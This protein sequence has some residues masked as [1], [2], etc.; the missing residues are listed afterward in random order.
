MIEIK[1]VCMRK[2][3]EGSALINS[4]YCL[5]CANHCKRVIR[6]TK[7]EYERMINEEE[8]EFEFGNFKRVKVDLSENLFEYKLV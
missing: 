4:E 2:Y 5:V 1:R 8:Q 3:C 6:K 7:T